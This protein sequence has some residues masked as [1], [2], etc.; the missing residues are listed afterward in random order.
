MLYPYFIPTKYKV[1][2]E[3]IEIKKVGITLNYDW[4]RF[5][6]VRRSQKGFLLS[7]L[8][9]NSWLDRFRG[10]FVYIHQDYK[11]KENILKF[12]EEQI[13]KKQSNKTRR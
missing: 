8:P 7:T 9:K 2:E 13:S 5:R 6:R 1:N 11:E 12:I 4:E 3:G 10:I